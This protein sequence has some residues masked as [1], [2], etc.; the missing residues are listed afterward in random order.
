MFIEPEESLHALSDASGC[1]KLKL[2]APKV[3]G[4]AAAGMQVAMRV[5]ARGGTPMPGGAC[6]LPF[7]WRGQ[8]ILRESARVG[9]SPT[10]IAFRIVDS[11][12]RD[13]SGKKETVPGVMWG[14]VK[15]IRAPAH[16]GLQLR[17]RAAV[18]RQP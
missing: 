11:D 5:D 1:N 4:A 6:L 3:E 7:T 13:E 16:R 8:V 18:G 15:A 14:W 17:T 9:D 2:S 10:A 12:I